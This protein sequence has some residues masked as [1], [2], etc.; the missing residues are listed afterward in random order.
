MAA[1]FDLESAEAAVPEEFA[2][3]IVA[4]EGDGLAI[5]GFESGRLALA[6]GEFPAKGHAR[7]GIGGQEWNRQQGEQTATRDH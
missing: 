1:G 4:L 7:A 2:G 3:G 5:G 6:H